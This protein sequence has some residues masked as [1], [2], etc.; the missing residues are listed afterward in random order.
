VIV[1]VPSTIALLPSYAGIE[2]P[3]A[4]LR[5]ACL[6]AVAPLAE[7]GS[8]EVLCAPARPDN[9]ERGVVDPAGLRIAR[10]LLAEVGFEGAV[11]PGNGMPLLVVANGSATRSEKAPGH[12]DERAFD[13]DAALE[14]ALRTG[15]AAALAAVDPALAEEL[16][17]HDAAAFHGLASVLPAGST[18]EVSY[19]DDPYG[20]QY[21]VV[22]WR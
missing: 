18:G 13:F 22:T 16:W 3:V 2:D 6:A 12:L 5:A 15:D 8:V 4:P 1:L 20:V 11:Q 14:Q 17:C 7:A 9:V 10:H 21:W 19:A